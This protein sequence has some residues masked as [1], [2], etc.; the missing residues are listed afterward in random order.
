MW[1]RKVNK[2]DEPAMGGMPTNVGWAPLPIGSGWLIA[3][4]GSTNLISYNGLFIPL[5]VRTKSTLMYMMQPN[6]ILARSYAQYI[7]EKSKSRKLLRMLH[8]RQKQW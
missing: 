4:I 7:V 8:N 5:P 2:Q 3:N 1:N 6:E